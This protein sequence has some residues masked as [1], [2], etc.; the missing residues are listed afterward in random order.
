MAISTSFLNLRNEAKIIDTKFSLLPLQ[1][2]RSELGPEPPN[3]VFLP[4]ARAA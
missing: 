2:A 1:G 4:G 3:F